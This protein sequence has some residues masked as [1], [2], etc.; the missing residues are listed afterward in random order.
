MHRF[1]SRAL[2]L[3][4]LVLVLFPTTSEAS[5]TT[6][7]QDTG[8][9]GFSSDGW[10]GVSNSGTISASVPAGSV[11]LAAY[12]YTATFLNPTN[13]GIGSTLNGTA[14]AYG[15]AVPNP[16]SGA[17]CLLS[18]ARADVTSIVAGVIDG[19]PG[20]VYNFTLTEASA[21]QDG[22]ALVVVY[23]NPLLPIATVGILDG[24]SNVAGDTTSINF[25]NPLNPAAPGFFAEMILADSFSCCDQKSTV[26]VNGTVISNQ[27]G[28]NDDG[29]NSL[30]GSLITVGGF[31]DPFSPFLPSYADDHERYNLV[32]YV[33]NG[34][35]SITIFT[36][37]PDATDNIFMATF[38][39][40]GVAGVNTP[41]PGTNPVPEPGTIS[42]LALGGAALAFR[43]FRRKA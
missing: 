14:V 18:S 23:S 25:L 24:F 11:V 1:L 8:T 29:V 22:E 40:S 15:P 21:S 39:V 43:R 36:Q 30:N 26:S 32:P 37:N 17:C 4:A 42:L 2:S 13:A 12:L 6:F 9:V 28:N 27:A 19:G 33:T 3:G 10:G 31:N 38:F 16:S 35:T 20:G 34:D 5:L 41:P 7:Q